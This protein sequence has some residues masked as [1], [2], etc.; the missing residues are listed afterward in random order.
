MNSQRKHTA[1]IALSALALALCTGLGLS[2]GAA[3]QDKRAN[4]MVEKRTVEKRTVSS[5][6]AIELAGPFRVIVSEGPPSLE[7]S[8]DP[9]RLAEIETSVRNGKLVVRQKSRWNVEFSFGKKHE[10]VVVRIGASGLR[11]LDT[12]G[13][14]DVE[15]EQVGSPRFRLTSSGPGDVRARGKVRE[16]QV[17]SSGSGDLDLRRLQAD[18][19]DLA[20]SGPG[21][22]RVAD[23][24]KELSARVSGPGD[25]EGDNLRLERAVAR[26]T[27]PGD[28]T[29]RGSARELQVEVRGPG[30]FDGCKLEAE[31][32]NTV[33]NGPGDVCVAGNIRQFEGEVHG[34]GDLE[35]RGL[36]ADRVVLRM[37]GPGN[38]TLSELVVVE[39]NG[40][41]HGG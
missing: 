17:A 38:A 15:L 25:L 21:D 28:V 13:S 12:S 20:M 23:I 3:A 4:S 36:Q 33:Q 27:G 8:G 7:L 11:S 41:R 34:P 29:L 2:Q 26:L 6:D 24:G 1:P 30:D 32:V 18:K 31:R 10:G 14:G 35:A 22:V 19:L 16:L 5:F 39:R 37:D 40:R 9:A